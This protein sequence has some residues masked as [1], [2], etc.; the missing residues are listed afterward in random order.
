MAGDGV[1]LQLRVQGGAC[2]IG[3]GA[4]CYRCRVRDWDALGRAEKRLHALRWPICQ[5]R[6]DLWDAGIGGHIRHLDQLIGGA[7][8]LG[9]RIGSTLGG[10]ERERTNRETVEI[11]RISF[12]AVETG[13]A[14][15]TVFG[16]PYQKNDLA[17][18]D[19]AEVLSG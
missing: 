17:R 3:A 9:R 13:G 14:G 4:A 19:E 8:S 1:H 11:L 18:F 7:T 16:F 5:L 12:P 6:D 2:H 10:S 15:R